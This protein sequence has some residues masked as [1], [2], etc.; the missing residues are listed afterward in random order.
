MSWQHYYDERPIARKT[1]GCILCE[2]KILP[3]RR[4]VRR[5]GFD[6]DGP[7]RFA[8]HEHCDFQSRRW[9]DDDWMFNDPPEFRRT[10]LG[11]ELAEICDPDVGSG[12]RSFS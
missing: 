3:G 6:E 8:L 2:R 12:C 9:S 5:H 4:Y 1:H 10:E 11:D 7:V